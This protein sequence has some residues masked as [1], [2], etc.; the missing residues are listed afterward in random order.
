VVLLRLGAQHPPRDQRDQAVGERAAARST[1]R[2]GKRPRPDV[3]RAETYRIQGQLRLI[4][5]RSPNWLRPEF[6]GCRPA[7]LTELEATAGALLAYYLGGRQTNDA[8][9]AATQEQFQDHAEQA[10]TSCIISRALG[11]VGQINLSATLAS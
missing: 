5:G 4:D 7:S 10:K 8:L 11:G 2:P 3:S 1:L 9:L 6:A